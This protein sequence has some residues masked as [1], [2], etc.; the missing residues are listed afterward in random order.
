MN[1]HT[2]K[3]QEN[4]SQSIANNLSVNQS[5]NKTPLQQENNHPGAIQLQKI[6]EMANNSPQVKKAAQLQALA[7]KSSAIQN[8]GSSKPIQRKLI[9]NSTIY[10]HIINLIDVGEKDT[11]LAA[12]NNTKEF[13]GKTTLAEIVNSANHYTVTNENIIRTATDSEI[14]SASPF[15]PSATN[16]PDKFTQQKEQKNAEKARIEAEA[17][18]EI[19]RIG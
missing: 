19:K 14:N 10:S 6:Q 8:M 11:A 9:Y 15:I 18:D 13:V 2:S 12:F 5:E 3:S 16:G 17:S 1:T 7:D 4:K